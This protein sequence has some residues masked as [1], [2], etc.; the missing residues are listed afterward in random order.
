MRRAAACVLAFLSVALPAAAGQRSHSFAV[1]AVVVKS[2]RLRI[3]ARRLEVT[4]HDRVAVIVDDA[5]TAQL[6][7]R[8]VALPPGTVRVT[9]LY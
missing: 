2:A 9:V 5:S 3:D 4:A 8:E 6:I 1:G 7:A